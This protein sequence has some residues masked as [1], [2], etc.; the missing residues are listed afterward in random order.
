MGP[1]LRGVILSGGPA[2][3]YEADAP[4]LSP[5]VWAFLRAARVPVLGVCYGLQELTAALGGA[6]QRA[7]KREF[8]HAQVTVLPAAAGG[9]QAAAAAA[10]AAAL[11]NIFA[12]LPAELKVWMSH[13]DKITT[14]A[15]GLGV[16]GTSPNCEF[17]AVAGHVGA[18]GADA[19]ARCAYAYTF[20]P[21]RAAT[22]AA[23]PLPLPQTAS[24]STACSSTPR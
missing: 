15:P 7:D 8:G 10:S 12:G 23:P 9:G 14:L 16:V 1:R 2:S 6:V 22:R 17:A 20:A 11:P 24:P 13:G 5:C 21:A 4:H 3:V 19:R 18:C